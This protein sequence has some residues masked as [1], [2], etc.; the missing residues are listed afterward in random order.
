MIMQQ[1]DLISAMMM[2]QC[3]VQRGGEGV[4]K[5]IINMCI[6]IVDIQQ[7]FNIL[8]CSIIRL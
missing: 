6:P 8:Q 1:V 4:V 2:L 3:M 5:T 7:I